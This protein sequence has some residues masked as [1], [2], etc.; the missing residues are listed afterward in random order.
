M[1]K[2]KIINRLLRTYWYFRFKIPSYITLV[3]LYSLAFILLSKGDTESMFTSFL[4]V[5]GITV[6]T[7][8]TCF[9]YIST[10]N[11][12]KTKELVRVAGE[13]FLAASMWMSIAMLM[14][15]VSVKYD[16]FIENRS[17]HLKFLSYLLYSFTLLH[18]TYSA[19]SINKGIHRIGHVLW[20]KLDI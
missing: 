12:K 7:S 4:V 3:A 5:I 11:D 10:L 9:A 13:H 8:Q 15:F 19:D 1:A 14:F 2:E 17:W 20:W 6:T 16:L 18:F